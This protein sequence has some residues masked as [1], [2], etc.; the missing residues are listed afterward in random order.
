MTKPGRT[1]LYRNRFLFLSFFLSALIVLGAYIVKGIYPFGDGTLLRVDLYHQYAPFLEEL[2]YR[3][4]HGKSLL[5]SWEGGLGKDFVSQMAYYAASPINV[6][7]FLF[8]EKNLPEMIALF[9]L[10]KI[11]FSSTSFAWF[12]RFKY[13]RDDITL[14]IF[15]LLYGFCVLVSHNINT[16]LIW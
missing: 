5:Y 9:I 2:H 12:L 16:R 4:L 14:T 15:G 10:L 13:D 3:L 11:S 1:F 7:M 6:L 8:P